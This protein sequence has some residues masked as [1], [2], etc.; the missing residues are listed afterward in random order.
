MKV[1]LSAG[2]PASE[3]SETFAQGMADRM[4]MSFFK[5][6]A[7]AEAYPVKVDAIASLEIRLQKYRETGNREYLL[8]VGNF[9]MIEFMHPKHPDAHFKSEDSAASPGR[10]WNDGAQTA[11]SNTDEQERIRL[12]GV[13]KRPRKSVRDIDT[14]AEAAKAAVR[15]IE[16]DQTHPFYRGRQGD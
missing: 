16:K 14:D 10:A 15:A 1:E 13:P 8:D 5:Y 6:G 2:V 7:V 3:F 9:A 12:G 4:S 11:K